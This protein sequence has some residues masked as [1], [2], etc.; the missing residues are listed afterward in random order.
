MLHTRES[1]LRDMIA[2]YDEIMGSVVFWWR[3]A[4]MVR[5]SGGEL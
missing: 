4:Q 1:Y 3:T 2:A 5:A